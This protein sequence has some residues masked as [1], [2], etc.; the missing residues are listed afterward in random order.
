MIYFSRPKVRSQSVLAATK[1][2]D[3]N[4]LRPD[5]LLGFRTV[6]ITQLSF[7][8]RLCFRPL[9]HIGMRILSNST[10]ELM[11]FGEVHFVRGRVSL[12]VASR[13]RQQV[14]DRNEKLFA[15]NVSVS[16]FWNKH[17]P[18]WIFVRTPPIVILDVQI[19]FVQ[20]S[21][22]MRISPVGVTFGWNRGGLKI[23]AACSKLMK[24]EQ[25]V[26][27]HITVGDLGR[28]WQGFRS[29]HFGGSFG[30]V[31]GNSAISQN[32]LPSQ[33]VCRCRERGT[34]EDNERQKRE[35]E[36]EGSD[37]LRNHTFFLPGTAQLHFMICCSPSSSIGAA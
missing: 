12:Q 2:A 11:S 28:R 9:Q 7:L 3:I 16:V 37:G 18:A 13:G 21:S 30:Y 6:G 32:L 1:K 5:G 33:H 31:F 20:S 22:P 29:L 35:D 25:G 19:V 14:L 10:E 4:K 34:K 36:G 27:S 23:P 26:R 24:I 8:S 15:F 17:I